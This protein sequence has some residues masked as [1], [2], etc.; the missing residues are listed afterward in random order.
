[1]RKTRSRRLRWDVF[2]RVVD[3]YGDAAVCWR[4]ARELAAR[5]PTGG[6][7]DRGGCVRLWIDGLEVLGAL[8]PDVDVRA[9]RQCVAGVEILLWHDDPPVGPGESFDPADIAVDAF[10]CGLPDAY[11]E[12]MAGRDS[13][14]LWI[15]L[16]YLS[17][18]PWVTSHHGLPS[19]HPRL[20]LRR[21]FFF[22]GFGPDTGGLIKEGGLDARRDDFLADPGACGAFWQ[23][24]GFAPLAPEALAVSLFG[25]ENAGVGSL[26]GAWENSD[27]P[28]VAAVPTGK[29]LPQVLAYFDAPHTPDAAEEGKALRRGNLEVRL[30]PFLAQPEY[31]ELLWTCDW[32]F[33]RGEDSFVRAQWAARPFVW[34]IYPQADDAH[35]VKLDAFL[36]HWCAGLQAESARSLRQFWL[37]W[38]GRGD[39]GM[40]WQAMMIH[41]KALADHA[42][43]W[44]KALDLAGNLAEKLAQF[45]ANRLK[46]SAS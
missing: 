3:N 7:A 22:P 29:L 11:A 27:R 45:C 42:R 20:A 6:S 10:G 32:N 31:D 28:V 2:C 37:A 38:N 33:V 15:T 46:S 30:L 12:A 26:L 9:A 43:R 41:Q 18:E 25:Y 13:A 44:P 5:S 35:W 24:R 21:Y 34:Q 17:A 4:L 16:E 40:A 8:C 36:D 1:M 19:P 14:S 39:C 23:A